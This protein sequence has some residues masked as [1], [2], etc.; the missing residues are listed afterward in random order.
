MISWLH[1]FARYP[2]ILRKLISVL[3]LGGG[4][5][6]ATVL[7]VLVIMLMIFPG[8]VFALAGNKLGFNTLLKYDCLW[9][10]IL[11]GDIKETIS[12]R[13]G[14]SIFAGHAPVFFD[15]S[16]DK[17]VAVFLHQLDADH[18]RASILPSIG[19]HLT[20]E[21]YQTIMSNDL[22]DALAVLG[23]PI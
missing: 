16:Q 14:K 1:A 2:A 17:L 22:A 10:W 6:V 19:Q 4:A 18:V 8:S 23:V 3:F 15:L 7:L 9:N 5:V 12:S 13:L 20:N 11:G 21:Q